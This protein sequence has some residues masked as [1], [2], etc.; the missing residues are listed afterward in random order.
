MP[1]VFL[2]DHPDVFVLTV[3]DDFLQGRS[4]EEYVREALASVSDRDYYQI[5]P[6]SERE[7]YANAFEHM[8]KKLRNKGER[9]KI[10]F[11]VGSLTFTN[12]KLRSTKTVYLRL[13]E[14]LGPGPTIWKLILDGGAL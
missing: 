14:I 11:T 3:P 8:K 7:M 6:L 4:V 13:V 9:T 10:D 5:V 2:K 1:Q 12:A